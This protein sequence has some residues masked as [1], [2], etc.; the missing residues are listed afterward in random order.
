MVR[1]FP[2]TGKSFQRQD[3][4]PASTQTKQKSVRASQLSGRP[5][6]AKP[7]GMPGSGFVI[8]A[9][10]F[11]FAICAHGPPPSCGSPCTL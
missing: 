3:R 9:R 4:R 6:I 5:G 11:T 10:G 7:G 1:R 2:T 8:G